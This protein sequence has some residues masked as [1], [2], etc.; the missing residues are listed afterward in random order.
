MCV[1]GKGHTIPDPTPWSVGYAGMLMLS[2]KIDAKGAFTRKVDA[3]VVAGNIE[4]L[5]SWAL[6]RIDSANVVRLERPPEMD[7]A[8]RDAA[9]E[10]I[11]WLDSI[12]AVQTLH[13]A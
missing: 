3:R 8:V 13:Q 4:F 2:G 6:S 7:E 12:A 5:R 9:C 11:C 10:Y 1:C